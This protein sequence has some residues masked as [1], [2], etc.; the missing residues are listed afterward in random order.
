MSKRDIGG[1]SDGDSVRVKRRKDAVTGASGAG[2]FQAA[3][4]AA[5]DDAELVRGQGTAL[6][7]TIRTAVNKECVPKPHARASLRSFRPLTY[8]EHRQRVL[9]EIF[10]LLPNKRQYPDYYVLITQPISLDMIRDRLDHGQYQSLAA[11][12]ADIDLCFINAKQYNL[13]DSQVY[14]DARSLLVRVRPSS[15]MSTRLIRSSETHKEGVH[16]HHGYRR[17]GLGR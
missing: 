5:S 3:A 11:V 16:T 1:V 7:D 6:W 12:K 10:A 2:G 9:S 14:K 8:H 4:A 15:Y 13:P 17:G